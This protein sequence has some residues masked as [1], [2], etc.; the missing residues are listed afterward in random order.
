[1]HDLSTYIAAFKKELRKI[2]PQS[3]QMEN[4]DVYKH[5][6][7]EYLPFNWSLKIHIMILNI[8]NMKK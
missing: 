8:M 1:M 7:Q 3:K 6:L 4:L 5:T 2:V